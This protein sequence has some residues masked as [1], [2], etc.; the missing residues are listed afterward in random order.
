MAAPEVTS[1]YGALD[2]PRHLVTE[3][4]GASSVFKPDIGELPAAAGPGTALIIAEGLATMVYWTVFSVIAVL[5]IA[6]TTRSAAA[7]TTGSCSD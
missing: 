6:T 7:Q 4:R 1:L 2:L 3:R 5:A